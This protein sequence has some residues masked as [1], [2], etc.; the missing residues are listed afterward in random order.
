MKTTL[1][2]MITALI[3]IGTPLLAEAHGREA[4]YGAHQQSHGW[5]K[6][7]DNHG[8]QMRSYRQHRDQRIRKAL[9]H[10]LRETRRELRHIRHEV[11]YERPWRPYYVQNP[12]VVI[13]LPNVVFRFDW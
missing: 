10:E 9:E 6:Q 3:F 11:R 1:M 12:A 8:Q 5:V 7:K 2:L 4:G 13:G